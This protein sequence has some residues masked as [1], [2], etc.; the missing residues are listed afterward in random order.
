MDFG[1]LQFHMDNGQAK[2][3]DPRGCAEGAKAW[4][5]AWPHERGLRL[6]RNA[7]QQ[8]PDSTLQDLWWR[9]AQPV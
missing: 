1:A 4:D 5:T 7:F 6:P 8:P 3:V 2:F 9:L